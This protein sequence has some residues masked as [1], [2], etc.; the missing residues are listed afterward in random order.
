MGCISAHLIPQENAIKNINM[1]N[2]NKNGTRLLKFKQKCSN[3]LKT[4]ISQKQNPKVLELPWKDENE[5]QSSRL[6]ET[7]LKLETL[8]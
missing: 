6:V 1:L 2:Q 5:I 3:I 4:S 7:T 8:N